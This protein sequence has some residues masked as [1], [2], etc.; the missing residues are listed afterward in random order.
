MK[1]PLAVVP[2]PGSKI[3]LYGVFAGYTA[4]PLMVT[5]SDGAVMEKKKPEP[6]VHRPVHKAAH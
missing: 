5:M 6:V 2:A 3:S 4:S 1:E